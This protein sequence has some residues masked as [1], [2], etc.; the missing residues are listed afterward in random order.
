[1]NSEYWNSKISIKNNFQDNINFEKK[2]IDFYIKNEINIDNRPFLEKAKHLVESGHYS[3]DLL[4]NFNHDQLNELSI[5]AN[6]NKRVFKS[7]YST[8]LFYS[9]YSLK[10]FDR[11]LHY[12]TFED[13]CLATSLSLSKGNFELAKKILI[14]LLSGKIQPS[15]TLFQEAGK[16]VNNPLSSCYILNLYDELT[17]VSN[18]LDRSIRLAVTGSS[19]SI[20][21]S[22]IRERGASIKG[23]KNSSSGIIP[24]LKTV[25]QLTT[26]IKRGDERNSTCIGWLDVFHPDIEEF[27]DSKKINADERTRLQTLSLGVKISD[28][29]FEK[30]KINEDICLFSPK[31]IKDKY[32]INFTDIDWLKKYE[33]FSGDEELIIGKVPARKI[34]QRISKLQ[35]ESGYPFLLFIDNANIENQNKSLGRIKTTNLCTEILQPDWGDID[36]SISSICNISSLNIK[37]VMSSDDIEDVFRT[38]IELLNNSNE[39]YNFDKNENID[40]AKNEANSIV[41]SFLDLQGYLSDLGVEYGTDKSYE[42][43]DQIF[44]YFNYLTLKISNEMAIENKEIYKGFYESNY[45]NGDYFNRYL[46]VNDKKTIDNIP[47]VSKEEWKELK[48]SIMKYGLMHSYRIAIPPNQSTAYL[49]EATPSVMPINKRIEKRIFTNINL[50]Y[51]SPIY[52][53]ESILEHHDAF[54]IGNQKIIKMIKIIQKHVDQSISYT[55]FISENE[56]PSKL[57]KDIIC[58]WKNKLKTVY[59]TR[60]IKENFI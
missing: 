46:I 22:N 5:L 30:A 32:N 25:E 19:I 37:R 56:P 12:E 45:A 1:M 51:I 16:N 47:S 57:S 7:L 59:Y 53:S 15:T 48:D 29:F 13:R 44:E 40:I 55:M 11:K 58:A 21:L 18:L 49:N 43:A 3:P 27:L 31:A 39:L 54:E 23:V 36:N 24:I 14:N 4:S 26:F 9:K 6:S 17:S 38:N 35:M 8:K 34:L 60:V 28:I 52:N 2:A 42:I 20:D 50:N 33:Q 10:S 41:T